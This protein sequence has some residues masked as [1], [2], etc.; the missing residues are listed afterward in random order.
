MSR[1]ISTVSTRVAAAEP[2][3]DHVDAR[4]YLMIQLRDLLQVFGHQP[5]PAADGGVVRGDDDRVAGDAPQLTNSAFL[6]V[7]PVMDREHS[8]RGVDALVA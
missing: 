4:E 5:H 2:V 1:G 6:L 8:Q 7:I 3:G